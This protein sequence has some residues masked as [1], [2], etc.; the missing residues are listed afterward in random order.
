MTGAGIFRAEGGKFAEAWH[1][2]NTRGMLHQL[3]S[4]RRRTPCG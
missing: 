4:S 1:Q 3:G 2:P